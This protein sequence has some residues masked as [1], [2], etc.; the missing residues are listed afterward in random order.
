MV[1]NDFP[2]AVLFGNDLEKSAAK[3]PLFIL[4]YARSPRGYALKKRLIA[5]EEWASNVGERT[6]LREIA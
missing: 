3:P 2:N 4:E 1:R 5:S 6:R